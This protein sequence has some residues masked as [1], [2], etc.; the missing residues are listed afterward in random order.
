MNECLF[1]KFPFICIYRHLKSHLS[2]AHLP[3]DILKVCKVI[4]VARNAKDCCV[5]A[6]HHYKLIPQHS[7]KGTFEEFARLFKEGK[8]LYGDFFQHLQV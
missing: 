3:A 5:S 8:L 7:F 6:Y 2:L 1:L 4:Y